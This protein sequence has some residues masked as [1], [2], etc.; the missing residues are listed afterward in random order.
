MILA[1][2]SV[3]IHALRGQGHCQG[4]LDQILNEKLALGHEFVF[5]E[6]MLGGTRDILLEQYQKI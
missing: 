3:W 5:G 1:D 2:T 6:L 4:E